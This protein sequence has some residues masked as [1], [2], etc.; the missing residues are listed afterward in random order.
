MEHNEEIY[1][2]AFETAWEDG[3][4]TKDEKAILKTLRKNIG[5]S[6]SLHRKIENEITGIKPKKSIHDNVR[7][8]FLIHNDGRLISSHSFDKD[9]PSDPE[10]F[11][12]MFTAV[13]IFMKNS[14][15][16][17]GKIRGIKYG[18]SRIIIE[19]SP[20]LYIT[21][22]Y[23][24]DMEDDLIRGMRKKMKKTLEKIESQYP[25][26]SNWDGNHEIV[27][28]IEEVISKESG[29]SARRIYC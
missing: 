20:N 6:D 26:I 23:G 17:K 12:S 13:Q 22:I 27:K 19:H 10:I 16:E 8:I 29:K 9:F 11:S 7:A 21:T 15:K 24:K 14:L 28:N 5:I 1:R 3:V 25:S 4:L 2:K 18:S